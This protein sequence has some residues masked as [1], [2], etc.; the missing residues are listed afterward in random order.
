[1]KL[2][3]LSRAPKSKRFETPLLFVHGSCHGAWCW[4]EKFLPFFAENG[5]SSHALS[6]R[7]HC[8]SESVEKLNRVSAADYVEDVFQI[9]SLFPEKPVVI[10]H[11]L[12]G[13]VVQKYL[14]KHFAPAAVL[15]APSPVGGMF[16][17]GLKLQVKNPLLFAKVHIKRDFL[18]LYKTRERAKKFLFSAD[19]DDEKIAKYVNRF[20]K[21]SY[22]AAME[23][24]H[25]LPKP[26]KIKTPILVL[27]AENDA[28]ISP[29][30][31]EKT[32]RAYKA[33]YKI[34]H[35]AA[36]DIMLEKNWQKAADYT[37]KWLEKKIK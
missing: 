4:D 22:R 23:M 15:I 27:G 24:I 35:D 28:I 20:G 19:A 3:V 12:G 6:L 2:E 31:I 25:N 13:F 37:I 11:S 21:E 1:M 5:F 36:H 10:G 8:A 26:R 9:A 16:W 17:S 14:E 30:E 7:G 29:K 34:F 33:E 32:A 18:L